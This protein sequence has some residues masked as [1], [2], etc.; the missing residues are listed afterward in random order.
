MTHLDMN[1]N[2]GGSS[3][4]H[5]VPGPMVGRL[6][7]P[8]HF[9]SGSKYKEYVRPQKKSAKNDSIR[10]QSEDNKLNFNLSEAENIKSIKSLA[11]AYKHAKVTNKDRYGSQGH[12][13]TYIS[14]GTTNNIGTSL[15]SESNNI[16]S[17][18]EE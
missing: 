6:A 16:Y 11:T 17:F 4:I 15:R 12:P 14:K 18:I 1:L 10:N 3:P 9:P 13:P 8:P 2:N 7:T 5:I